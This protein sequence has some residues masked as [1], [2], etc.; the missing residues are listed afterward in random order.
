MHA[1]ISVSGDRE[2]AFAPE[3]LTFGCSS[4]CGT[5]WNLGDSAASEQKNQHT[6]M[7]SQECNSCDS[8]NFSV[9]DWGISFSI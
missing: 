2:D 5:F 9:G 8:G 6:S 4:W 3:V 7:D 1:A